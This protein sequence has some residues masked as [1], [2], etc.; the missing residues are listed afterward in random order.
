MLT[1]FELLTPY[2]K[3]T[4]KI[5]KIIRNGYRK[6]LDEQVVSDINKGVWTPAP[7]PLKEDFFC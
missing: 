4:A 5:G 7:S 6:L 1:M 2:S 3:W